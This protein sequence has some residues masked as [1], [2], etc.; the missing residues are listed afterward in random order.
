MRTRESMSKMTFDL[1]IAK[2]SHFADSFGEFEQHLVECV[3]NCCENE[4]FNRHKKACAEIAN[5]IESIKNNII[6]QHKLSCDELKDQKTAILS[7]IRGLAEFL[8]RP[9]EGYE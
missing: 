4:I 1:E 8:G 3:E 6:L 5:K 2:E 7:E 9:A